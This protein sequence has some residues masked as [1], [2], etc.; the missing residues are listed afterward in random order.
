MQSKKKIEPK[1]W[2]SNPKQW[3]DDKVQ[4]DVVGEAFDLQVYV[5]HN[6]TWA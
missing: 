6:P 4:A 1:K 2:S 5:S 3:N